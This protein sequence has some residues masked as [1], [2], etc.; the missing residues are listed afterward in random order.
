MV[1]AIAVRI[2]LQK[3]RIGPSSANWDGIAT[4]SGR[5]SSFRKRAA[6]IPA[7]TLIAAARAASARTWNRVRRSASPLSTGY[8]RT[9]ANTPSVAALPTHA[10]PRS[11][12]SS[13]PTGS[14]PPLSKARA[15]LPGSSTRT[16]ASQ[17]ANPKDAS[18]QPSA[19]RGVNPFASVMRE[20]LPAE[21]SSVQS[22]FVTT[23]QRA[24]TSCGAR[25]CWCS[26]P[27]NTFQ[28][29]ITRMK[30]MMMMSSAAAA[31]AAVTVPE[32]TAQV[33][34]YALRAE[35]L[36]AAGQVAALLLPACLLF[37]GWGAKLRTL[38]ARWAGGSSYRTLTLFAAIYLLLAAL[39]VL[40]IR[41]W[42]AIVL[43]GQFGQPVESLPQFLINHFVPVGTQIVVAALFLWL[44]MGLIRKAPK[45]W[46]LWSALASVPVIFA[47]LVALPVFVDPLMADYK[48]LT[49]KVLLVKIESFATRCG[50]GEIPVYVGGDDDTVV[51]LGPTNRVFHKNKNEKHESPE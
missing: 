11:R 35:L 5:R 10:A 13:S 47:V 24:G 45:T 21:K 43:E 48:P 14:R 39:F 28:A 51:G 34:A 46:W 38:C 36:W 27:P 22:G 3:N 44:F 16:S 41:Y 19:S 49:D 7:T 4:G 33:D 12:R 8:R 31:L 18:C 50:I 25:I 32:N 9:R 30:G 29:W 1:C 37:T 26:R 15:T 23:R 20:A 17:Y 6:R 40:P 2:T 42:R